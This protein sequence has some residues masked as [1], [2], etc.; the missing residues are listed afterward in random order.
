MAIDRN[1]FENDYQKPTE[2]KRNYNYEYVMHN[3]DYAMF[4]YLGI[5]VSSFEDGRD[6]LGH[7]RFYELSADGTIKNPFE[8][9]ID[10]TSK[11]FWDKAAQGKILVCPAGEKEPVQMIVDESS[12]SFSKP[13]SE[14]PN[15]PREPKP[16]TGFRRFLNTITFGAAYRSEKQ[17]YEQQMSSYQKELADWEEKNRALNYVKNLRTS[18]ALVAEASRYE[19]DDKLRQENKLRAQRE[20]ELNECNKEIENMQKEQPLYKLDTYRNMYQDYCA[21]KPNIAKE[22]IGGSYFKQDEVD[23]LNTYELPSGKDLQGTEISDREFA[24]LSVMFS[25]DV[26][27]SGNY[28]KGTEFDQGKGLI[29]GNGH[30]LTPEQST[31]AASMMFTESMVSTPPYPRN[32]MGRVLVEVYEPSRKKVHEAIREYRLQG[33]REKLAGIIASGMNYMLHKQRGKGIADQ[34]TLATVALVSEAAALLDRDPELKRQV[35]AV[36]DKSPLPKEMNEKTGIALFEVDKPRKMVTELDLQTAKGFGMIQELT[37]K[38]EKASVM[39]HGESIGAI[40]LTDAQRKEYIRDRVVYE[41]LAFNT[42]ND[43]ADK[44]DRLKNEAYTKARSK[45]EAQYDKKTEQETIKCQRYLALTKIE[46]KNGQGIRVPRD[47][48]TG[49]P[50]IQAAQEDYQKAHD[51]TYRELTNLNV[52]DSLY[53]SQ[54]ETVT[55]LGVSGMKGLNMLV[56]S[57]LPNASALENLKGKELEEALKGN[58][59]FAKDSPYTQQPID[60]KQ[61]PE[62]SLAA[63]KGHEEPAK[64]PAK[65]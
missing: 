12:F 47:E 51:E 53:V 9:G 49:E 40:R 48:K 39:L 11:A 28:D 30:A 23:V 4:G 45:L 10:L 34:R 61:K 21:P 15:K 41:T 13:L 35:L 26:S 57:H 8:N 63:E 56:E 31:V 33:K 6:S 5:D 18:E 59:L 38:N 2:E 43:V 17:N 60:V 46:K 16:L 32:A 37:R 3:L 58:K 14:F 55:F 1:R 22:L 25:G 64:A 20:Q 29:A 54:P 7:P 24:A 65:L 27:I 19:M 52:L 44:Q 50:V 42:A 62:K 36:E